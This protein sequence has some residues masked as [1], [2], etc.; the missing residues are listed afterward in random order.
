MRDKEESH[1]YRYFPDPD[2]MP[3]TISAELKDE[4][5]KELPELPFDRQRRYMET[6][7]LPYTITSVLCPDRE[8]AEFFEDALAA[9]EG[10][11]TAKAVANLIVNELLRELSAGEQEGSLPLSEC[12]VTPAHIAELVVLTEEG[13]ITKQIGKEVFI[14]MYQT[15]KL[16][17]AIVDEKGLQSEQGD[18][19][20]LEGIIREV[21]ADPKH[22]KAIAQF[23]DGNKKAINSLIGPI[24]KATG[25]KADPRKIQELL[26]RVL[27]P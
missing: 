15:G 27:S 20:E 7:D 11:G 24:M 19:G 21:A 3:V 23:K 17:T 2:L 5:G 18:D 14:A 4:L 22:D 25:G 10:K 1:D 13:V 6:L 16:P 12:K 8:L 9:T 26:A